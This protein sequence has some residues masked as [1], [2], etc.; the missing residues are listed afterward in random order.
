MRYTD[1]AHIVL[2]SRLAARETLQTV[3]FRLLHLGGGVQLH[4]RVFGS[5]L[6][7]NLMP[8]FRDIFAI[9]SP[10]SSIIV[11]HGLTSQCL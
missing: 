10:E 1:L 11:I 5:T 9:C 6:V 4:S 8:M 2:R 7:T 3:V